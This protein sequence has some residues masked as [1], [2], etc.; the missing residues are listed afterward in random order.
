MAT[1]SGAAR[2]PH[3]DEHG[4]RLSLLPHSRSDAVRGDACAAAATPYRRREVMNTS[5]GV[6]VCRGFVDF[7]ANYS[8]NYSVL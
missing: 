7:G 6:D 2:D 4:G 8:V 3:L 1:G 5:K